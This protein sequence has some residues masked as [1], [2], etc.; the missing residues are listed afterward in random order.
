MIHFFDY[1]IAISKHL[2]RPSRCIA[3]D[4]KWGDTERHHDRRVPTMNLPRTPIR[5]AKA[6]E[7]S[8]SPAAATK[9]EP[10][11]DIRSFLG[12]ESSA[13]R[14]PPKPKPAA[15]EVS[16]SDSDVK[17]TMKSS[18][19]KRPIEVSDSS[20]EERPRPKAKAAAKASTK[21]TPAK[22]AKRKAESSESEE[23][24]VKRP[25]AKRQSVGNGK[26]KAT[27]AR[28]TK[29]KANDDDD[30]EVRSS[31]AGSCWTLTLSADGCRRR[32]RCQARKE[33]S[34]QEGAGS[35]KGVGPRCSRELVERVKAQ[36][37]VSPRH[38]T[39]ELG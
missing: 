29:A 6:K 11:A 30:F 13:S 27:A 23:L 7:L 10:A 15:I 28:K 2:T 8:A 16:D 14:K 4:R 18:S 5:M 12:G 31:F 1:A 33:S 34:S 22:A 32:R 26:A 36:I 21:A 3:R 20:E 19:S 9:K 24:E 35:Q 39:F 37:R 38:P 25:S 17:P